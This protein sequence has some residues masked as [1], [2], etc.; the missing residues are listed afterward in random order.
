E[1]VHMMGGIEIIIVAE[2][3]GPFVGLRERHVEGAGFLRLDIVQRGADGEGVEDHFIRKR[4]GVAEQLLEEGRNLDGRRVALHWEA[5]PT[6]DAG[7]LSIEN[8]RDDVPVHDGG[9]TAFEAWPGAEPL[10]DVGVRVWNFLVAVDSGI[11]RAGEELA[12]ARVGELLVVRDTGHAALG[13]IAVN[14]A[15]AR[16]DAPEERQQ[17]LPSFFRGIAPELL[18]QG[19]NMGYAVG[20]VHQR[21]LGAGENLLPSKPVGGD[22]E[23]VSRPS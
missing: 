2:F 16:Y 15:V 1:A 17:R 21:L 8:P 22:E 5:A 14:L 20:F 9:H 11:S 10:E 7:A 6:R 19:P 4:R 13:C 23:H 3:V 18:P 12:V